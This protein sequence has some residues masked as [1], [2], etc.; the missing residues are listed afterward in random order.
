MMKLYKIDEQIINFI[1]KIMPS[2]STKIH[3]PH[4]N[5]CLTTED[6]N[7]LRGIFQGDTLST[8]LF[9]LALAPIRNILKRDNI[10][11]KIMNNYIE[12]NKNNFNNEHLKFSS[13]L[14]K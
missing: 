9:C 8:L 10:G 14:K 12:Q 13:K 3:L 1:L 4:V 5:G 2:W 6:I 11:Y 7:F